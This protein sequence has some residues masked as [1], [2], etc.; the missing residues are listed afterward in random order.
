MRVGIVL[1]W[2]LG[3]AWLLGAVGCGG[4]EG[5]PDS[6]LDAGGPDGSADASIDSASGPCATALSGTEPFGQR[7]EG[8][9]IFTFTFS[10]DST[11]DEVE[12]GLALDAYFPRGR[13][14]GAP[15]IFGL[16][17]TWP[18]QG[19][20]PISASLRGDLGSSELTFSGSDGRDIELGGRLVGPDDGVLLDAVR[21]FASADTD[22]AD[23]AEAALH[24]CPSGDIAAPTLTPAPVLFAPTAALW[25]TATALV[26]PATLVVRATDGVEPIAVEASWSEAVRVAPTSAFPPGATLAFDLGATADLIGRPFTLGGEGLPMPLVTMAV[27]TDPTFE[28][29]PPEGAVVVDGASVTHRA[30]LLS[31]SQVRSGNVQLLVALPDRGG[32]TRA[33]IRFDAS[34][35]WG[36]SQDRRAALVAANGTASYFEL[37]GTSESGSPAEHVVVL[38]GAGP[39]WLSVSVDVQPNRP[40]SYGGDGAVDIAFDSISYE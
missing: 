34:T 6:G 20:Y 16:P 31:I 7:L 24:L 33:R 9:G 10:S 11:R 8:R 39:L 19:F 40:Q 15:V 32:A 14:D 37:T 29:A 3:A 27:V 25:F 26:D 23:I 35:D 12:D 28:T 4:E 5:T 30:G 36:G 18:R 17:T 13:V 22:V 38:P 21:N 2:V 1:C